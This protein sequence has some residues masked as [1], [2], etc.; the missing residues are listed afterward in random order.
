[1]RSQPFLAVS[2]PRLSSIWARCKIFID[3]VV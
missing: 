2:K 3:C 1:M